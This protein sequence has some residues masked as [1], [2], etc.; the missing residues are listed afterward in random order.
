MA[1]MSIFICPHCGKE[2]ATY[3]EMASAPFIYSAK[4]QCERCGRGIRLKMSSVALLGFVSFLL[5][6]P[7]IYLLPALFPNLGG[8]I[9]LVLLPFLFVFQLRVSPAILGKFGVK[10]FSPRG[11]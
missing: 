2:A 3:F 7:F 8:F 1:I 10:L 11:D 6:A 5:I 4:K 9:L